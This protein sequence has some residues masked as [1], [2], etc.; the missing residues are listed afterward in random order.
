MPLYMPIPPVLLLMALRMRSG[1]LA[2]LST[3]WLLG[4]VPWHAKQ[5]LAE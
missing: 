4:G 1:L 2:P 5:V 3:F